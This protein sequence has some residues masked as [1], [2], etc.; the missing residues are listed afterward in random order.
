MYVVRSLC[1]SRRTWNVGRR[2]RGRKTHR[3]LAIPRRGGRRVKR[4][5]RTRWRRGKKRTRTHSSVVLRNACAFWRRPVFWLWR[6]RQRRPPDLLDHRKRPKVRK[7]SCYTAVRPTRSPSLRV[8]TAQG[9]RLA[10]LRPVHNAETNPVVHAV[11]HPRRP[12]NVSRK[13]KWK[14]RMT[15]TSS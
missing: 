6:A 2:R 15:A 1:H 3:T 12:R 7:N 10:R 8:R 9:M 14:T 4:T 11:L 5:K 13:S